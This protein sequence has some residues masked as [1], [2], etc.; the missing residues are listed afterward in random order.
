MGP[1]LDAILWETD[2]CNEA[3]PYRTA[4]CLSY[5]IAHDLHVVFCMTLEFQQIF[6]TIYVTGSKL[7][8]HVPP[9]APLREF[10]DDDGIGPERMAGGKRPSICEIRVHILEHMPNYVIALMADASGCDGS[11]A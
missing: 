8:R 2:K 5:S 10:L 9:L 6:S 11:R 3:H 1:T 7:I 4:Y